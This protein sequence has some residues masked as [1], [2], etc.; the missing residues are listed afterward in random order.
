MFAPCASSKSD[1]E[2]KDGM[3]K[4]VLWCHIRSSN[5]ALEQALELTALWTDCSRDPR[6]PKHTQYYVG[7]FDAP[8]ASEVS[9]LTL[10]SGGG[11]LK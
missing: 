4:H 5:K 6:P 2:Q 8:V 3:N 1:W 10:P 7:S 9:C 11:K